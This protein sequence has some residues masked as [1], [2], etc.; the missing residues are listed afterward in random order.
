MGVDEVELTRRVYAAINR[1]DIAGALQVVDAD[2]EWRMSDTFARGERVFHGHAGVREA[3]AIFAES[4]EEIRAEPAD[5]LDAG[6]AVI[7]PVTISGRLKGGEERIAYE[8]VQ[9]W[10]IRDHRV[11]RI[12]VCQS[13]DEAWS[14]L[15]IKPPPESSSASMSEPGTGRDS[16]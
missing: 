4:L 5:V 15:G 10:S 3:L 16:R 8:L 9:V 13:L 7:A 1:G 12:D 2:V 14:A 6:T 11:V